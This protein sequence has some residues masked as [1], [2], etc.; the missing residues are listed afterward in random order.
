MK[1]VLSLVLSLMM[2]LSLVVPVSAEDTYPGSGDLA[3][4]TAA[5]TIEADDTTLYDN[6][7]EQIVKFHIYAESKNNVPIRAFQFTLEPSAN[8]TLATELAENSSFSYGYMNTDTLIKSTTNV[9]GM[10]SRF[11]YTPGSRYFGAAGTDDSKGIT[12]RTEVMT[13]MGKVRSEGDYTLSMSGV[14]AGNG[15]APDKVTQSFTSTVAGA[16][17]TVK[18][19]S[20]RPQPNLSLT[21][22]TDKVNVGDT[23]TAT[24]SNKKMSIISFISQIRFNK[25]VLE[26][27]SITENEGYTNHLASG[28]K[29]AVITTV[30]DANDRGV[31]GISVAKTEETTYPVKDIVTVTFK[32][33]AAGDGRFELVEST[34]GTDGYHGDNSGGTVTVEAAAVTGVTVSG[35][36][37]S[38]GGETEN[39]TVTL[40]PENGTPMT[41]VV[42]GN[43][44]AYKFEN[45]SAGTYTLKVEKK[46]HA[47]WTESI[48]VGDGNVTK[49]VTVYLWGDVNRDGKVTAADAQE[50]Q[51]N[52]AKLSS[53]YDTEPNKSYWILRA[54]VNRDGKVTAADAQEIQRS[55]AKLSSAIDSLL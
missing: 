23:F 27:V 13:I 25:D 41:T 28:A 33:K 52:A 36:V 15:D 17:V 30:A 18:P 31:V 16:T 14:V 19:E 1:K 11:E 2:L 39:V 49:D 24:L 40:T 44:A 55:A 21:L 29:T 43:S 42:T 12:A 35:T 3:G 5:F 8:L 7:G 38:Y 10:Y 20:E 47:P 26:V 45:V 34:D 9:D 6:G 48:T 51:R 32:A 22:S 50:I 54:D 37:K 53:A 46:G 4:K